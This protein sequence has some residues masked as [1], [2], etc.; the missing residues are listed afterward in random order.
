MKLNILLILILCTAFQSSEAQNLIKYRYNVK[1][2]YAQYRPMFSSNPKPG[3]VRIECNYGLLKNLETGIYSGYSRFYS[4]SNH[5]VTTGSNIGRVNSLFYGIT[6]NFHLLPFLVKKDDF[7]F[8][9]YLTGKLG[10]NYY[11]SKP[12]YFPARGHRTEYNVGLGLSFYLWKHLGLFSEFSFG[13]F[14]YYGKFHP[15]FINSIQP[16]LRFGLTYKYHRHVS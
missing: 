13:K 9:F 14:S 7:R 8:D 11:F 15:S 6:A 12:D 16:G 1:L 3:N 4:L 2:S 10:G 5:Q